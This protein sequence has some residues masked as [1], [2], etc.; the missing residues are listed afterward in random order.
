VNGDMDFEFGEETSIVNGCGVTLMGQMMY[1]GG[2]GV[3]KRQVCI[4]I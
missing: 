2:N 4:I 3:Q 1:F